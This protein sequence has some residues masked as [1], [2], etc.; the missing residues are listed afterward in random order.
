MVIE[1][2]VYRLWIIK[3]PEHFG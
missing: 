3:F 2:H 1:K